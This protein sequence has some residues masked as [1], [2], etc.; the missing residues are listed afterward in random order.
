MQETACLIGARKFSTAC[1]GVL[2]AKGEQKCDPH[3][4]GPVGILDLLG[5]PLAHELF[6][7]HAQI[8]TRLA[9]K[10]LLA[11]VSAEYLKAV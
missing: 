8:T 5:F 9:V 3:D 7:T 1:L 10:E 11:F 4:F 6:A 2:P